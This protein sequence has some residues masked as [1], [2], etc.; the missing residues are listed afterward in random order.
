MIRIKGQGR[1]LVQ[2]VTS[3]RVDDARRFDVGEGANVAI[4][5]E[6]PVRARDEVFRIETEPAEN[7][8]QEPPET[9]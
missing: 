2:E 1:D 8:W 3:M 5:V 9:W 4:H 7:R 6:A